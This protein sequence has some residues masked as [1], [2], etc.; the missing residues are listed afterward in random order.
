[1]TDGE[2]SSQVGES[3]TVWRVVIR[4][5]ESKEPVFIYKDSYATFKRCTEWLPFWE[6][7]QWEV[8]WVLAWQ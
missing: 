5:A 8:N 7:N 6:Q 4:E 3:I 2:G 1:M